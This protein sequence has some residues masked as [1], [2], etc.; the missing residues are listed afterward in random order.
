M[1][2]AASAAN[3]L[4][5]V[6]K[7]AGVLGAG[8]LA[9]QSCLFV[10]DAGHRAIVWDMKNGVQPNERSE[11]IHFMIPVWNRVTQYEVRTRP[12][13]LPTTTG[14][15]DLQQVTLQLRVLFRPR[16]EELAALHKELGPTFTERTLPSV[17]HEVLKTVVAH[18]DAGELISQREEVSHQIRELFEER[19]KKFHLI[20]DDIAITHLAFSTEFTKAIELK[21]VEQQRAEQSKYVVHKAEQEK[22]AAIIKASGEAEAATLI[23]KA[24]EKDAGFIQ[25]RRIEAARDIAEELAGNRNV[26]YLPNQGGGNSLLLNVG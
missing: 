1:A 17:S 21:Q 6:A 15:R 9:A 25:L 12:A 18:F 11:G 8:A 7:W 10:V 19:T 23:R 2:A 24:I 26:V 13:N 5:G 20:I 4:G 3:A 16:V 14:S 22:K